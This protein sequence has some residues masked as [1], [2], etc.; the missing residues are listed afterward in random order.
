M[1]T[2]PICQ[3]ITPVG[4]LGYGF[5]E[6]ITYYELSRLV[7]KG[8]PT[9]I[10][11]DSGSTDSGPQKL[12]LGSMS[13]PRS[14]YAQDLAKLLRLVHTFHVPLIFS[15]AGG[16]GTDEHVE[17]M[18]EI[19]REITEEEG[20][21]DYS[22]NVIS[23][24]ANINK[25]TILQRFN[26]GHFQS[27][28]PCVPPA[29]E[30][31]IEASLRVVAQMGYEPFLD[32][33]NANPNFDVIIGGR[34]Y[35]PA[36]Y[37][38][39]CLHQLMRQTDD[40]S[41]ERLHS[42]LGGFLH[43]GKILECGGQCSVPKSH[44]AVAT[45]YSRG[46]FD[47]RPTAPNSKCT[48]LSVAAHTLY[49]N[50][51]PDI[52]RGPGGS[53][54]LQDSK[55]EQLSDERS[56]RVSGSRYRSSEEDGLP[57]QFK[58][59]SARIVGYRSMFMGSV[60]DHVLV[61]Q[62]DKLLARVKLYVAQ[63]HTEPTSQ[64]KLDFHV[65]GKDQSNAAG[66]APLFIVAEALAP[67]QKLANSIASKARVGMIHAPYPGQKAT[68]GNF[69]FGLGGLMEVELGPCA[70]FS[71]YHLIDLEPDEQRLFLVDNGKSQTLQGPLLRGT[72]SHIG[73]GCP[74]PGNHSPPTIEM[75]IDPPLQGAEHVTPTQDQPVQNPKTLSDLCHV[76]RSKNAGPFE[77]TIDAIFSSKLNY[78]TIK[79][80]G[81]LSV[82][83]VAKVIGIAEDD[84]IWIGFF[85]P[86]MSFKVT[87]PRIRMGIKKSAGGI[88]KRIIDPNMT[89][90]QR[91]TPPIEELRQF[92]VGKSIHDVP[93][94]A[95]ILDK[96]RIHRHCQ[97]MLTAVDALGLHFRAHVKTHK[98]VEAARLQVGESNRDVKLIVS[99]LAEIDHLLPLLKEYKKAGRRLDI[100]YGL[101]LPRSQISRL[102]AFGAELGPGSISVLIDHPSQLE[103]VKA[104]SQYAKF[105]AR[106][107]LKV[108]TG[109]H[110]AGLPPISMNK[111]GLI[112]MLAKLEANGEAELL[113]L[114]SHSSLSY[115][116]S[117]PEQAM[118]NLEGE[119]QGCLDAVNA[120]AYL[121]AKNKEILISV[122]ASP[123]V[124]AAEN[125]VTAEGDLSPAAESLRRA[126]AT[127]TNG[128]PGG[129]QTKLELHAGVYSILDMQ[130]VS[131]NSRR[132]LGSHA[133]EIAISVIAE[134]CSTYNDNERVQPEALVAVGTLGLGREPCAAYPG[135]GVVSESSYDA[136]IGHKRRLIVDR[137]SQEHSILAWEHAEGE[138]T[139]LLPPVPLEV[140]HD[141][142][143]YP[144]HACVTGALYGWYLVVD[145][146]E[147]DAKKIVD[148]WVRASGW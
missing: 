27:C 24:F 136:G 50:T 121:F 43:M 122:G 32:A 9:A 29:T 59:E 5:D 3:I 47:V 120:Q 37:A 138:D 80:S 97:S 127:V 60:K 79:A 58:L 84:I 81:I 63:Q 99:T 18:Q 8:I 114:Y 35:D 137:I 2:K 65:Y 141:V 42:S 77:V 30:T 25:T 89:I 143:I 125:L 132:H 130:Q 74:K 1:D 110:R 39:Y 78:D 145:S 113:G 111:S 46:L 11:M 67:T 10:I 61:P 87:I 28:G 123:Q 90:P 69:G 102:A 140:G 48:P 4:M 71:L 54:H 40:L 118:E 26:Q 108:D 115:K 21:S 73:K 85:D 44:G 13:C 62:I 23:L 133:D 82:S 31:D 38:A 128:Q 76:L 148:V 103:S 72:I 52:L 144:N 19:I 146:S 131:T 98:T 6:K 135:W 106:V 142:V 34:A 22:F 75:N 7:S 83:N 124:T 14:A 17:V 53:I 12:A 101:P 36:P 105:P 49:E 91:Q 16:D 20:N 93:K 139:S 66:P 112:E 95:V 117:T 147:G 134:V 15:S 107:F 64:W 129:L 96:A 51:R 116:D 45:V 109:Y 100:L 104:F 68:A 70:E 57:Y 86:A 126:I 88:T 55:Y 41:N 94:P 92:Y 119:I 33:M 56:V